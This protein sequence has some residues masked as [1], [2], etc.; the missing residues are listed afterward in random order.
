LNA[1]RSRV[2]RAKRA[3]SQ[4]AGGQ[5]APL[6][7]G[8]GQKR[9]RRAEKAV[10]MGDGAGRVGLVEV[11]TVPSEM[12]ILPREVMPKEMTGL[13]AEGT[14]GVDVKRSFWIAV[15]PARSNPSPG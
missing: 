15:R 14:V 6:R 7:L 2:R 3:S 8:F 12:T 11:T 10:D 1:R 5:A 9:R 4:G 13:C